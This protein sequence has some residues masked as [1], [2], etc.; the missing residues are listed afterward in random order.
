M[1]NVDNLFLTDDEVA[2]LSGRKLRSAQVKALRQMGIPFFVNAAGRA[3]VARAAIEGRSAPV[4]ETLARGWSPSV[5]AA[6]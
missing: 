3:I 5:L 1:M 4:A 2:R 6:R